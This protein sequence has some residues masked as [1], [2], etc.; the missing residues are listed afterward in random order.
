MFLGTT[1][2]PFVT[3]PSTPCVPQSVSWWR[4][5]VESSGSVQHFLASLQPQTHFPFCPPFSSDPW[6]CNYWCVSVI[7]IYVLIASLLLNHLWNSSRS[8]FPSPL[9]S[10][11]FII[12]FTWGT[13]EEFFT[14]N[15][16]VHGRKMHFVS[17]RS[18]V[19]IC[20]RMM[21]LSKQWPIVKSLRDI[22]F[23]MSNRD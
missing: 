19:R 10:N 18:W 17:Y 12:L 13:N 14:H 3:Q 22:A 21:L 2:T 15:P 7:V 20:L 5:H 4:C 9:S 16:N 6:I 1:C 11:L 8:S 23:R